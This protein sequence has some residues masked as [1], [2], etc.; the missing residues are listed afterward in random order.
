MAKTWK[1]KLN[2][3]QAAHVEVTTKPLAGIPIGVKMLIP[4]PLLVR[5]YVESI[6]E[7]Q[8]RTMEQMRAEL[9]SKFDALYTCPLTSGIFIRIVAEAALDDHRLGAPLTEITPFWRVLDARST[10][11]KKLTCGTDFLTEMRKSEL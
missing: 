9:A 10:A 3:G 4:T 7:G 8:T 1:Q 11:G 6:P 2:S 5:E